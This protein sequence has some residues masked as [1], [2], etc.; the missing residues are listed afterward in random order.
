MYYPNEGQTTIYS[1]LDS[2]FSMSFKKC[3][4]V[5]SDWVMVAGTGIFGN[6]TRIL[7][8]SGQDLRIWDNRD[9]S[10]NDIREST[11]A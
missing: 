9:G 6:G 10:I 1:G 2:G 3:F 8:T 7:F 11:M 4:S 5:P